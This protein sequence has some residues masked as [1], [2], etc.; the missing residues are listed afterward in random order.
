MFSIS[1]FENLYGSRPFFALG[2]LCLSVVS[3]FLGAAAAI[4]IALVAL[5][6]VVQLLNR[7]PLSLFAKLPDPVRISGAFIVILLMTGYVAYAAGQHI[8]LPF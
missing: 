1:F 7:H 2:L 3:Y 8:P 5:A 4:S 6:F